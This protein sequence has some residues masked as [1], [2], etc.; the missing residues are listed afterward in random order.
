E[1]VYPAEWQEELIRLCLEAG[2]AIE[3]NEAYGVPHREFLERARRAGARFSVGSDTHG[4]LAP[5]DKTA[6]M[7]DAASLPHERFLSGERISGRERAKPEP[8]TS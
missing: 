5:L 3:V 6:A 2:V 8:Q 4:P 7:I 1:R